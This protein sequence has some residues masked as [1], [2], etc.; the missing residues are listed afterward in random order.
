[1]EGAVADK[2]LAPL[3]GLPAFAH[4]VRA[5]ID[6][7]IVDRLTVVYRDEAQKAQLQ[8]AL[9]LIDLNGKPIDW[10]TG[11][12]ERQDSVYNA[13]QSQ[14]ADCAYV[15]IHDCARPLISIDALQALQTAV[16]RDRAAVLA[17]PVSDTIKRVPATGELVQT[18]LDDLDRKRLW[19][20]ETPQAFAYPEILTAYA[21]V[22]KQ[23]LH[24][25]DD[26]AAA[27]TI[28]LK[29]TIVPNASPNPKLTTPADL[30]YAECLL[31]R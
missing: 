6:S 12:S 23:G 25:T 27:A 26:T 5:F 11:G 14:P 7:R 4:S 16:Q 28:G 22:H 29:I 15:Y 30:D 20:M 21:H 8:N 13:L 24:I 3:N 9:I 2:I 31:K 18:S 1:M 17:H 10:V 19:A